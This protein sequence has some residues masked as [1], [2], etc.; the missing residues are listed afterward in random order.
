MER[1][2]TDIAHKILTHWL[3]ILSVGIFLALFAIISLN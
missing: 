3:V 1:K 2:S